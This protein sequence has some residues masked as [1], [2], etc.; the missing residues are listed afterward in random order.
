MGITNFTG[1]NSGRSGSSG[2]ST[3]PGGMSGFVPYQP[4]PD[5]DITDLLINYNEREKNKTA[6]TVLFRDEI[7][8]QTIGI[9]IGKS[10]PNPLLVGSAGV[11]KTKIVEDI[12]WRLANNDTLIP[13]KLTGYTIYELPIANLIAGSSLMGALEQ[14]IKD[15]IAFAEDP[16]N[17]AILFIDEIHQLAQHGAN[18][19][20]AQILK[21]ALARGQIKTIGA[22]T[23]QESRDLEKDPAFSRRFSKIIVNE[24]T[25]SQTKDVLAAAKAD[26]LKHYLYKIS[27]SDDMLGMIVDLAEEY[28][29]AHSHRPD[30]ALTLFDRTLAD[31]IVNRKKQEIALANNPAA[32]SALQNVMPIPLTEKQIRQTAIR[33]ATGNSKPETLNVEQLRAALSEIKGQDAIL[34][35]IIRVLRKHEMNLTPSTRPATM[36]FIGPSGVG[37]T[38]VTKIIAKQLTGCAPIILNMTEYNSSASVNRILGSWAGYADS[39][40]HSELP[41]D[42]LESNPYQIILLDEFEKGNPAVQKLFMSVFDEGIMKTNRG[43]TIDFSRAIIIATTNAGH[44]LPQS[45]IGFT[46]TEKTKTNVADLSQY[47]DIALINRFKTKITFQSISKETYAEILKAKYKTLLES[48]RTRRRRITLPDEIPDDDLNRMVEET[49]DPNFGARPA[50]AAIEDFIYECA[51]QNQTP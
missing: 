37:K 33:L 34:E 32:L 48:I 41:F 20:I 9:L 2:I 18:Q 24:L 39:D 14:K 46:K 16:A 44:D 22:T 29:S 43:T 15:V 19:S 17:K 27:I 51:V 26:Y 12:A 38:E 49:Y 45:N 30:N 10:K 6:G 1:T 40:S 21:P 47:M 5:T 36:L 31:T 3:P 42:S 4:D 13:D 50:N 35:Q 8:Q 28:K 11:G 7:I 25:V 23:T